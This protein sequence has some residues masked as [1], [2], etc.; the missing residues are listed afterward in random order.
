[1]KK[2]DTQIIIRPSLKKLWA[3][4]IFYI[5]IVY[6]I[7][8]KPIFIKDTVKVFAPLDKIKSLSSFVHPLIHNPQLYIVL[9]ISILFIFPMISVFVRRAVE[10]ITVT[11]EAI[12]Y[13]YSFITSRH[14]YVPAEAIRTVDVE[15][16]LWGRILNVGRI[17][18][19]T[20]ATESWEIIMDNVDAPA[21][22]Q[23]KISNVINTLEDNGYKYDVN[24]HD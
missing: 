20:A 16:D 2:E 7:S 9:T 22:Q 8:K 11:D 21:K 19:G 4:F 12:H 18:V 17:K 3:L 5:A 10:H 15:Q 6:G 13:D 1:M 24:Q 23:K 14:K